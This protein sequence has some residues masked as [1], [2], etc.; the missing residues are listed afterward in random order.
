MYKHFLLFPQCFQTASFP[1]PSQVVIVGMGANSPRKA[2]KD[3]GK[4]K[5]E[6]SPVSHDVL[7]KV[8]PQRHQ[9]SS[10]CGNGVKP[11]YFVYDTDLTTG[12]NN[13]E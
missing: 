7:K 8:F 10:L 5:G 12:S 1:D 4:K 2:R 9:K 3:S 13:S 6:F 11:H